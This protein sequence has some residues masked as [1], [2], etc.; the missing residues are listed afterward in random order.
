MEG[1]AGL[2]AAE[3]AREAGLCRRTVLLGAA[4][5]VLGGGG[6]RADE[7]HF[8]RIGTAATTGTYFQIGGI[9][10]S[11]ISNPPGSPACKK[12]ESCGVPGLVAVAQ[13]TQGSVENVQAIASGRLESALSQSDVARWA[14][15]GHGLF[16]GAAVPKL[17][18]ISALFPESVHVVVRRDD[19][20]AGLA[21]LKGKRVGLGERESGTL[22]DARLVL[23]AAGLREA[24][25]HPEYLRLAQAAAALRDGGL[26]A[27]FLVGGAPIPAIAELATSI[28]I[29]LLPLP[30]QVIEKVRSRYRFIV[31]QSI[32]G[33]VYEGIAQATRTLGVTALW[34]TSTE[35]PEQ[36]IYDI[37]KALWSKTTRRLL[38]SRHP[39]GSRIRL[40]SALKGVDIPLHPGADRYYREAGLPI[41]TPSP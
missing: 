36:L 26:D 13:A 35:V 9:L 39:I 19:F 15:K 23:Q 37:T 25:F 3:H 29:R 21:D 30:E 40:D 11:A 2:G 7:P 38:D 14:W 6:V 8:F 5:L 22:A 18:A 12:D 1:G 17:R 28:P 41:D 27:F 24:D 32:P 34:V 4:A 20:I 16:K 10:A 33:G 31:P